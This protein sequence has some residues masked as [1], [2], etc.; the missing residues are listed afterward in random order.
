MVIRVLFRPV[1]LIPVNNSS[2]PQSQGP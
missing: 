2:T 1:S